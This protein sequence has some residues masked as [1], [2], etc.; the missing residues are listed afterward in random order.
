MTPADYQHRHRSQLL[1]SLRR[2]FTG[3][4][5][6]GIIFG[7]IPIGIALAIWGIPEKSVSLYFWLSPIAVIVAALSAKMS[8]NRGVYH[9][10]WRAFCTSFSIWVPIPGIVWTLIAWH[11]GLELSYPANFPF[12]MFIFIFFAA[13]TTIPSWILALVLEI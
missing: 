7:G 12:N 10:L 2:P 1:G 13:A 3:P 5:L 4:L 8:L 6:F 9:I 11:M